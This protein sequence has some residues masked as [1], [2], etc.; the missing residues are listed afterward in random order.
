MA[1]RNTDFRRDTCLDIE[2]LGDVVKAVH[3]FSK[4]LRAKAEVLSV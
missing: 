3:E 1:R 2:I 4:Q